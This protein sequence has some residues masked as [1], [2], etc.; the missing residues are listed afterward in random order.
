LA[1]RSTFTEYHF[2]AM[3]WILLAL[4]L[5]YGIPI[6]LFA[7]GHMRLAQPQVHVGED[8]P[9]PRSVEVGVPGVT[10]LVAARNEEACI[11]S[12]IEALLAQDVPCQILIVD[13]HSVDGTAR[14][15]SSFGDR[16]RLVSLKDGTGKKAAITEGV[17]HIRTEWALLTDADTI[18]PPA[19]L[20]AM[21]RCMVSDAG[22]IVGPVQM[23]D[24]GTWLRRMIQLE[25]A[26][27][28][29]IAAGAIGIGRPTSACG[30]SVAFRVEAFS[31]VNGFDG[32]D[33]LT[34]G[35]DELLMQRIADRTQWNVV[36]CKDRDAIVTADA[37][38]TVKDFLHQRVRWASKAG[39]Y[40][41]NW[42]VV[43]NTGFWLFFLLLLVAT[44]GAVWMPQWRLMTGIAWIIK[45]GAESTLL[46]QSLHFYRRLPLIAG[47][48]PAQPFQMLYILWVSVAG[49]RGGVEWKARRSER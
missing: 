45:I 23:P 17:K 4:S 43:M 37:P 5:A 33:H 14:I 42:L 31:E 1:A 32:V 26:G 2:L 10:V 16:V 8:S 30:S 49:L 40:E 46:I 34:S 11:G 47:L 9:D 27:F 24:N 7:F 28:M 19:W 20:R 15:V 21:R 41:R 35:D 39:F 36:F 12:C 13:D 3:A 48:I 29:G 22:Y 25:W 6:L 44:I 18:A 38:V